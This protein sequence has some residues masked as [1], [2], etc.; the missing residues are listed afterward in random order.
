MLYQSN[1]YIYLTA[2]ESLFTLKIKI[3]NS[4]YVVRYLTQGFNIYNFKN[5]QKL[6]NIWWNFIYLENK[7]INSEYVAR[8]L[9]Q[10]F[11]IYIFYKCAKAFKHLDPSHPWC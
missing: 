7:I 10:G 4:E 8:Y 11:N 2:D 3:I 5:A 1:Q 9:T 6:L